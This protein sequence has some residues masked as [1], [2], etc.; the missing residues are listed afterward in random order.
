MNTYKYICTILA[1]STAISSS[2]S[3]ASCFCL[4]ETLEQVRVTECS[5]ARSLLDRLAFWKDKP[6]RQVFRATVERISA[7]KIPCD[8]YQRED[9]AGHVGEWQSPEGE[10]TRR[11]FIFTTNN[12]DCRYLTAQPSLT[13]KAGNTC[14]D[15]V[16]PTTPLCDDGY[17]G[18]FLEDVPDKLL[19][20]ARLQN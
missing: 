2:Q 1:V 20:Y 3:W 15:T 10:S 14:C 16:V 8:W 5:K 13:L 12:W 11:L 7:R 9:L 4:F 17:K 19:P 6:E 18:D